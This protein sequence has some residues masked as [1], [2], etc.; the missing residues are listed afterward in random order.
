[1]GS[2][3]TWPRPQ[4]PWTPPLAFISLMI[5]IGFF[6]FSPNKNLKSWVPFLHDRKKPF[7]SLV[8]RSRGTQT[9][10]LFVQSLWTNI[11]FISLHR[12]LG[13]NTNLGDWEKCFLKYKFKNLFIEKLMLYIHS[14]NLSNTKGLSQK[15]SPTPKLLIPPLPGSHS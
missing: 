4:T 15:V 10:S 7:S 13:P 3:Q 6:S 11:I 2:P 14:I 12:I 9:N 8:P 5:N 1:M